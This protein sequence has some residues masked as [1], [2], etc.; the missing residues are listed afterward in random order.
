M[1]HSEFWWVRQPP[2]NGNE[3]VSY[4]S[5]EGT[6][7]K[8]TSEPHSRLGT[9]NSLTLSVSIL[10]SLFFSLFFSVFLSLSHTSDNSR[11]CKVKFLA[12][13]LCLK[14]CYPMEYYSAIKKNKIMPYAVT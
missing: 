13:K 14:L 4:L 5:H 7:M 8:Q 12:Q 11:S 1:A 10:L 9:E 2:H 3:N 6:P